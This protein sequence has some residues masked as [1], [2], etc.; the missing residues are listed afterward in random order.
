MWNEKVGLRT[1]FGGPYEMKSG[2]GYV[3][4][5]G[6]WSELRT[7]YCLWLGIWVKLELG[8]FYGWA[9]GVI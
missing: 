1:F 5:L 6:I 2:T 4:W 8:M 9:Y 7:R 3:L